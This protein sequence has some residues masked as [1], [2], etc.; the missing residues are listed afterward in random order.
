MTTKK[1]K[2]KMK[3][4]KKRKEKEKKEGTGFR[5][6]ERRDTR[7]RNRIRKA[8]RIGGSDR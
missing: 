3:K 5:K 4:E 8:G 6:Y 7:R 2:V 1:E